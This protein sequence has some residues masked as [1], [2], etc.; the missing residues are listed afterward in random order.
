MRSTCA[1]I[2]LFVLIVF[3]SIFIAKLTNLI[4]IDETIH[5]KL[6]E[7]DSVKSSQWENQSK[8]FLRLD[9]SANHLMWFIHVN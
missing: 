2:V 1:A 9:G 6:V 7:Q 3:C 5:H 4:N 8:S